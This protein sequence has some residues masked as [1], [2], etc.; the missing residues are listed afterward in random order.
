MKI[1]SEIKKNIKNY[2]WVWRSDDDPFGPDN[3][4][5]WCPYDLE[6]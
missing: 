2:Q 3:N 1:T 4:A 6:K 5:I